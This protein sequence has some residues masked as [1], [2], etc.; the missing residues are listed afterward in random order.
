MYKIDVHNKAYKF[1]N[2]LE[3]SDEIWLKVKLLKSFKSDKKLELDIKKLRGQKKNLELYRLRVGG[4][5]VIFQ[6][7]DNKKII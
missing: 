3:N 5:R 2:S 7:L 4:I 6:V 1:I